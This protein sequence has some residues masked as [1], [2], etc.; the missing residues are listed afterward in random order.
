MRNGAK[1]I[2]RP[3]GRM[4]ICPTCIVRAPEDNEWYPSQFD[5]RTCRACKHEADVAKRAAQGIRVGRGRLP[6]ISAEKVAE[7]C[8]RYLQR[9]ETPITIAAEFGISDRHVRRPAKKHPE[10][11]TLGATHG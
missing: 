10:F 1:F 9:G 3:H 4:R 6:L 11:M 7:I 2:L 8:V 5:G